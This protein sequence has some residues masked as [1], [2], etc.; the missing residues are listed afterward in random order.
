MTR[1]QGGGLSGA[2]NECL[3]LIRS[4]RD[5]IWEAGVAAGTKRFSQYTERCCVL[6]LSRGGVHVPFRR[7]R[8]DKC[9]SVS[10]SG[11]RVIN[12]TSPK[13]TYRPA[14]RSPARTRL[15]NR[16]SIAHT[17]LPTAVLPFYNAETIPFPSHLRK[18]FASRVV[19]SFS[20][21]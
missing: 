9:L 10:W 8:V 6:A 1:L 12:M 21:T 4:E 15:P 14:L 19:C 2:R 17:T 3:K 18:S 11:S 7:R 16:P 13:A 5:E 20:A